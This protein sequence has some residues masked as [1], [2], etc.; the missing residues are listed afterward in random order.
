MIWNYGGKYNGYDVNKLPDDYLEWVINN[1]KNRSM[2]E[3]AQKILDFRKKGK[4]DAPKNSPDKAN[5]V[6]KDALIRALCLL[7]A[8]RMDKEN[9]FSALPD[10]IKYVVFNEIPMNAPEPKDEPKLD[11]EFK[12]PFLEGME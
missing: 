3:T 2:K 4:M 1:A 9:P 11:E 12:N 6:S 10:V 7:I 5:K 8:T